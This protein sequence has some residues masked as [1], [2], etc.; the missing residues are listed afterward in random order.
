MNF[1]N[2]VLKRLSANYTLKPFDCSDY[3]LND[4]FH[5]D[6][7]NYTN[8]L[9][10]VTYILESDHDTVAFFSMLNDKISVD[11][12]QSNRYYDKHIRKSLPQNKKFKS[13][14]AVKLGRLGVSR[15]YQGQGIGRSLVDY[16]K[17]LFIENN[18]TGCK[19]LT[20]DAYNNPKTIKFYE[21][22]GFQH[23]LGRTPMENPKTKLMYFD[24][25]S[26]VQ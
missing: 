7:I 26:L 6:A 22:N 16:V 17:N 23:L 3:D 2:L 19:F 25:A 8:S 1:D 18:R 12:A 15:H 4:F 10:A 20:V 21:N 11:D 14:P 24:L 13:Y 5:N 9:L